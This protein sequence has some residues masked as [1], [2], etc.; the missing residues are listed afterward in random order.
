MFAPLGTIY[1][2]I[3]GSD[4]RLPGG[5]VSPSALI[6][7]SG[8]GSAPTVTL[9]PSATDVR[10]LVPQNGDLGL[11]W[12]EP[13]F[14]DA[15]WTAG[16]T[17][18]GY[19]RGNGYQDLLAVDVETQMYNLTGSVYV[20]IPF[21]VSDPSELLFLTLRMKYDDGFVAYLNGTRVAA[22][23]APAT[24]AWNSTANGNHS[25][26]EAVVFENI[27]LEGAVGRLRAGTN[28]LAIHGLNTSTTSS[29][30]LIL[31]EL[32]GT[33][34]GGGE[35]KK[36]GIAIPID[37]TTL[38]RS[39]VFD[40][41][42][43][44][45][46]AL[47]EATFAV[48]SSGLRITEVMYHPPPDPLEGSPFA[49]QD[50]EFVELQN[51]GKRPLNL[52]GVRFVAG[53][54]FTFPENHEAA[55]DLQPGEAVLVVKNLEAFESRYPS[56]GLTIAGEYQGTLS[57]RGELIIL[58]DAAGRRLVDFVYSDTW[59]V[60]TDGAGHSLEILDQL[61]PPATWRNRASWRASALVG[62]SPGGA[63]FV[64]GG[65][66]RPGNINQDGSL[67]I[68]D[69]IG[70]L[71]Y[72]FLGTPA[73]LPCDG[74]TL[75]DAGNRALLDVN[76]DGGVDL[77]DSVMILGFLFGDGPPPALGTGCVFI[78]NCPRLCA[79]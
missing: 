65:L 75:A 26:S 27:D 12:T 51:V 1:Y 19:E 23:N 4:P 14:D 17:G 34:K 40:S 15:G 7:R 42:L 31:P 63:E 22:R 66:Q 53:I 71:R 8:S 61:A 74:G 55:G 47:N 25:D 32:R 9:V 62:G 38:V 59:Y 3:D 28:V 79:R 20:R 56:G 10:V 39:R 35:N 58:E 68:S 50:F 41:G 78:E 76:G 52:M 49:R 43:G 16:T 44:E 37:R 72:L 57:D 11:T 67:D 24:P 5:A 18:V 2:T 70:L 45:W 13:G 73:T 6:A 60:T 30:L 29:D 64:N 21:E 46:S 69:A 36:D 54:Q 33:E 48:D 77:A